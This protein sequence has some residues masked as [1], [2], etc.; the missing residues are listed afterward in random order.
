MTIRTII[1]AT[2]ALATSAQA[3]PEDRIAIAAKLRD[4]ALAGNPAWPLLVDLTDSVGQRLAGSEVFGARL[5]RR[6]QP[7]DYL[8]RVQWPAAPGQLPLAPQRVEDPYR[9]GLV[10]GELDAWLLAEGTHRRPHQ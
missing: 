5:A 6:R 4:T 7:F 1:A 2:L 9:F 10:L 8:L 3:A